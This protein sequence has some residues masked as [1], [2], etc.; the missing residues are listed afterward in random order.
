MSPP[1]LI[2]SGNLGLQPQ[3]HSSTRESVGQIRW[4]CVTNSIIQVRDHAY[5]ATAVDDYGRGMCARALR[6]SCWYLDVL[7]FSCSLSEPTTEA[8]RDDSHPS[9]Q[10]PIMHRAVGRS[11]APRRSA[12]DVVCCAGATSGEGESAEAGL[13]RP[14]GQLQRLPFCGIQHDTRYVSPRRNPPAT[15]PDSPW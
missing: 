11:N 10:A 3:L 7:D 14:A 15:Q 1:P 4:Q 5:I 8:R 6:S 12:D 13:K 9:A 2:D